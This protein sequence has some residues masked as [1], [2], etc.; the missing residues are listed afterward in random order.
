MKTAH[1]HELTTATRR[2]P[3]RSLW[4]R[5]SALSPGKIT[6]V[7]AII[8]VF[9]AGA[10]LGIG[11]LVGSASLLADGWHSFGDLVSDL[12]SWVAN[13]IGARQPTER[14]PDGFGRYEHMLTLSIAGILASGGAAMTFA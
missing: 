13:R 4:S 3:F 12:I 2:R 7:G 8:N 11:G 10:K 6:I 5:A 1:A 14:H 9:L